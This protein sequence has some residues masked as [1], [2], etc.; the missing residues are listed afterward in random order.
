MFCRRTLFSYTGYSK[1]YLP[2][3]FSF[4]QRCGLRLHFDSAQC[5]AQPP[6]TPST[7]SGQR[8]QGEEQCQ[9]AIFFFHILNSLFCIQYSF[10]RY[11]CDRERNR[12]PSK[13]SF[14]SFVPSFTTFVRTRK[15]ISP[16]AS[17]GSLIINSITLHPLFLIIHNRSVHLPLEWFFLPLQRLRNLRFLC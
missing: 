12:E 11:L 3:V 16:L 8:A 17:L 2:S 13:K 9:G 10:E 7:S 15:I 6:A 14:A 5:S 4:G 1:T